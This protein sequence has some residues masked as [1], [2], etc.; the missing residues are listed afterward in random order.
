MNTG[1]L[2]VIGRI[3]AVLIV[4]F[5]SMFSASLRADKPIEP[6][7]A[8]IPYQLIEQQN[9]DAGLFTQGMLVLDGWIYESSGR[10]GQSKLARYKES[11]SSQ[12][13]TQPLS[14]TIFAEGLAHFNNHFYLLTWRAGKAFVLDEYWSVKKTFSYQG[15]GWG[16][17]HDGERLIMSDGSDT[18]QF[19]DADTFEVLS[20]IRVTG[21]G[22]TWDQL[23]ELEYTDG[24]VWANRWQTSEIVAIDP[25]SGRVL[26]VIDLSALSKKHQQ[27]WYSSDK[28]ANGIAWSSE[29]QA[30]WVTGK[31]WN[32]RY[33]I[34][35]QIPSLVASEAVDNL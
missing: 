21:A 5:W 12:L 23:N 32:K 18:L 22:R 16:L 17:T 15:E 2:R 28:V 34:K 20:S 25:Q 8:D 35:P 26:G 9:H 6:T 19:R 29:R 33:L 31:Y 13:V 7:I 24:I 1:F 14:R 30:F 10:Y 3:T 27:G 4:G 11:D